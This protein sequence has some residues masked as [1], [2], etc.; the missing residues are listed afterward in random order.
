MRFS[1]GKEE[2]GV[3]TFKEYPECTEPSLPFNQVLD[4]VY[5]EITMFLCKNVQS[6]LVKK[7]ELKRL[8]KCCHVYA[9]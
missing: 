5:E 9:Q 6:V 2:I 1:G 8:S 7:D 4:V 3:D